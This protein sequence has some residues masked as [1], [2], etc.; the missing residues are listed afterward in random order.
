MVSYNDNNK[1]TAI[2][3]FSKTGKGNSQ[4][5]ER[6]KMSSNCRH[7]G[8]VDGEVGINIFVISFFKNGKAYGKVIKCGEKCEK[9]LRKNRHYSS[10]SI[11]QISAFAGVL[12]LYCT[13]LRQGIANWNRHHL[14]FF[15]TFKMYVFTLG[16]HWLAISNIKST[17]QV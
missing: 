10:F 7:L 15:L 13:H 11:L 16:S 9:L 2:K 1:K 6:K 14:L 12:I 5:V 4:Y 8:E 17:Q 3:M